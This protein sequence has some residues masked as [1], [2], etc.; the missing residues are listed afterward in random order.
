MNWKQWLKLMKSGKHN[1][2]LIE[3]LEQM[4]PKTLTGR[5][6]QKLRISDPFKEYSTAV[7]EFG[8]WLV[9]E[10]PK[11]EKLTTFE[12]FAADSAIFY[13][14][15]CGIPV[16]ISKTPK[17]ESLQENMRV[18][19]KYSRKREYREKARLAEKYNSFWKKYSK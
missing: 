5:I 7:I 1:P 16:E 18:L 10:T 17:K 4:K 11:K 8:R 12:R 9:E 15:S 3:L 14:F 2:D 6:L 13:M 19:M